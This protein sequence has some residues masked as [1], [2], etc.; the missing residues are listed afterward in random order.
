M[1]LWC[2]CLFCFGFFVLCLFVVVVVV[3]FFLGGDVVYIVFVV[4]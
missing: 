1:C 3:G 4:E 2:F